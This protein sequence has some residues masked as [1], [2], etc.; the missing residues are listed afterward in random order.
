MRA[1]P[2]ESAGMADPQRERLYDAEARIDQGT[3]LYYSDQIKRYVANITESAYWIAAWG[4]PVKV[5][6]TPSS[7][8]GRRALGGYSV[9][10]NEWYVRFPAYPSREVEARVARNVRNGWH[11]TEWPWAWRELVICHEL[12]HVLQMKRHDDE[13]HSPEFCGVFLEVV[14]RVMG[15]LPR[16]ELELSLQMSGVVFAKPDVPAGALLGPPALRAALWSPYKPTR[17]A[18]VV[19]LDIPANVQPVLV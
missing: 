5:R 1:S 2:L 10:R 11:V 13:T 7:Q 14:E 19:D 8:R 3:Q 12:A 16:R 9:G 4:P 18:P 6:I 15:R 17:L